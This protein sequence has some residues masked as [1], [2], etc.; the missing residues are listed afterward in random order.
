LF[1]QT[2]YL[3]VYHGSRDPRPQQEVLRVAQ[4]VREK[5]ASQVQS[6]Q[7]RIT[8]QQ[9]ETTAVLTK[10]AVP[11]VYT[12][13][14]ELAPLSL[15]EAIAQILTE[16]KCQGKTH[17]RV[18]PLFLLPGVHVRE[19]IPTA[20]SQAQHQV[21]ESVSIELA[22]YVGQS[23]LL[24]Q[25]LQE[26]LPVSSQSSPSSAKI[27]VSHGSRRQGGNQPI[28]A[29]AK[30]LGATTGYWSVS[31]TVNEQIQALVE[32]GTQ[33]IGIIPYFLFPGGLTDAIAQQVQ[34][35]Q[36]QFPQV[37]FNLGKPLSRSVSLTDLIINELVY[38]SSTTAW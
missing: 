26:S 1:E 22:P 25:K 29:L 34:H 11:F 30:Q 13:A 36:N 4:E 24:A 9:R 6:S 20:L 8:S 23:P 35:W 21:G 32:Q 33:Q 31:P 37:Q 5:L 7:S 19:D 2:A 15:E 27:I 17:L 18:L 10:P 14:L 3:L 28:E 38:D 12:A 16:L